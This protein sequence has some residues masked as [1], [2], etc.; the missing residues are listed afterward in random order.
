[1]DVCIS[2]DMLPYLFRFAGILH[3]LY[4]PVLI[5]TDHRRKA[6]PSI[7]ILPVMDKIVL[8]RKNRQGIFKRDQVPDLFVCKILSRRQIGNPGFHLLP[9]PEIPPLQA[10]QDAPA[11][12]S[13]PAKPYQLVIIGN[14][15][16]AI[17]GR[18]DPAPFDFRAVALWRL[19]PSRIRLV[20][21]I[22]LVQR[23]SLR[24]DRP[25]R[26]MLP[27][28]INLPCAQLQPFIDMPTGSL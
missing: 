5:R 28:F 25:G 22:Q 2:V 14:A 27:F 12:S 9:A 7:L 1:M 10:L 18:R 11:A 4:D 23:R 20:D 17:P 26:E 15:E 6:V 16:M 19:E 8:T 13:T 24:L 21:L 3:P